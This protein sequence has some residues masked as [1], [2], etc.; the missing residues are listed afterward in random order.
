MNRNISKHLEYLN[1]HNKVNKI[2]SK[3]FI[4]WY[5]L[6][7]PL[8]KRIPKKF[9]SSCKFVYGAKICKALLTEAFTIFL[10]YIAPHHKSKTDTI[11]IYTGLLIN[12]SLPTPPTKATEINS[13]Q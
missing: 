3:P 6:S 9:T 2:G 7:S 11:Y 12:S 1:Y 10:L 13:K 8:V 5:Q 4:I